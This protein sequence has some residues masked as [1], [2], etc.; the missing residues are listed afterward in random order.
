MHQELKQRRRELRENNQNIQRSESQSSQSG[1]R[2]LSQSEQNI[3]VEEPSS[4]TQHGEPESKESD[5][6]IIDIIQVRKKEKRDF[7]YKDQAF[8]FTNLMYLATPRNGGAA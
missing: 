1:Q 4:A 7:G 2:S 3:E 6:Q 8:Y 5:Q